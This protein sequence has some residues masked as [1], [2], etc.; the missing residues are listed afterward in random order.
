MTDRWGSKPIACM[1]GLVLDMDS[2]TQGTQFPGSA[3]ILQ[4]MEPSTDSGY[5]RINGVIKYDDDE[6]P[7]DT[8]APILGV[9]VALNGVFAARINDEGGGGEDNA[10]YF[11]SGSGWGAPLNATAR[12]G[13][14]TK[15]RFISYNLVEPVVIACDGVNPAWKTN[16][17]VETE[18]NGVGAPTNPKYAKEFL[19]RLALSG[20]GTGALLALSVPNDDEDFS[21]GGAIEINVGDTVKGL[22]LFRGELIIFCER[23]IKKLTGTDS[24]TFVIV[25]VTDSIGCVSG[26]TIQEIGGDLIYLS[27]DGIRSYAATERIGDVELSLVSRSIQPLVRGILAE[28]FDEDHYASCC[29]RKKSQYRLFPNNE[30]LPDADNL[31]VLGRLQDAPTTPHGQFEWA[32]LRGL[33]P[34]S[35][36][37]E[38]SGNL[39]VAVLGHTT[40]GFVYLQ[41]A[42]NTFDGTNIEAIYRTPDLTFDDATI[43][44]VFFKIDINTQTEG[45]IDVLVNL[46]LD[47]EQ[48]HIIQPPSVQLMDTGSAPVYGSAVYDTDTY[49]AFVFPYFKRNLIGSGFFGAFRFYCNDDSSPF[50]I[51]SFQVTFSI[52][53]RR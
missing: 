43:R 42:G 35:A 45:D 52:K 51:E 13:P 7:G 31:G 22:A 36:D 44:K 21:G 32:T 26:D 8:D 1:G 33:K 23:S 16:G 30:N 40:N 3:R 2:L 27:T 9:K 41:E 12:P 24:T 15:V 34:Y 11:G 29:V 50:R 37:S 49:G 25:N 53:G 20:Y 10:I 19:G 4:N 38:Y 39:E 28:G 6:V 5:R 48:L 47:K 17:T 14:V 46:L 18:I